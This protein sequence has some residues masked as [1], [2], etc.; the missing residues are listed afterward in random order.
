MKFAAFGRTGWLFDS[1]A[2]CAEHGHQPA[3]IGTSPAAPEYTVGPE[4]FRRLAERFDCPFFCDVRINHP[5]YLGMAA[6]SGAEVA[7]SVNWMTLIGQEMLDQFPLGVLNAHAGD[8]PRFRGNAAPNW[9]ILLGEPQIVVTVH[10]MA[11]ELD[12]GDVLLKRS[13]PLSEATTIAEVYR[14]MKRNIPEMFAEVL[15]GLS[16]GT[17]IPRPQSTQSQDILRCCPRLPTDGRINWRQSAEQLSRLVRASGEPFAGAYSFL[18]GEKLVVWSARAAQPAF[19][20]VG[21][22][23]QVIDRRQET[24]EVSILTGDGILVLREVETVTTGRRPAA[25]MIRSTRIRLGIEVE[26][27]LLQLK[28]RVDQLEQL[29]ASYR[30]ERTHLRRGE[31]DD[32]SGLDL[33]ADPA[34]V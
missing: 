34:A 5:D 18:N 10:K 24:G 21:I 23:G 31:T 28:Q 6:D 12:A 19:P 8:L 22:P 27:E 7:L 32:N 33:E 11:A 13:S 15:D 16:A 26:D 3:L 9:A 17:L 20:Q 2:R 25:E 30:S 4:D 1:I 29:L 14:F